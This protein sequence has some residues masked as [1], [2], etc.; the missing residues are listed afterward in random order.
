MD[1]AQPDIQHQHVSFDDGLML[2]CGQTL[3]GLIVA[4][5]TYGALNAE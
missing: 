1:T 4:Y 2:E 5:R 3:A